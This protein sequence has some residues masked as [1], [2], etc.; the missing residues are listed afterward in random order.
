MKKTTKTWRDILRLDSAP[1]SACSRSSPHWNSLVGN[2]QE[3]L[4][5]R[6]RNKTQKYIVLV[7][8]KFARKYLNGLMDGLTLLGASWLCKVRS[9]VT[10]MVKKNTILLRETL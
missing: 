7:R 4:I 2:F 9:G 6:K 5:A 3:I 1:Y 8:Q 10:T